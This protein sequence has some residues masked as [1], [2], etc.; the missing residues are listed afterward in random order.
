MKTLRNTSILT[1]AV[2]ALALLVAAPAAMATP[3][4]GSIAIDGYNQSWSGTSVTFNTLAATAGDATGNFATVIPGAVSPSTVSAVINASTITFT[5]PDVLAWTIGSNTATFT[6]TGPLD[7]ST[8]NDEFL[9]I[10]GTGTLTLSGYDATPAYLSFSA[11][12]SNQ[13]YGG[14]GTSSNYIFDV[15]TQPPPSNTP[16]PGTLSLFGTGLLG[17]AGMLRYRFSKVR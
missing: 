7:V 15:N 16:E 6:I 10:S 4:N 5:S 13:S 12:D 17:L 9:N 1:F 2:V 8:D 11:T 3:I 14:S